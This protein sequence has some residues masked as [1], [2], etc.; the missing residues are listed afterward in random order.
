MPE[1]NQAAIALGEK[2]GLQIVFETARMYTGQAPPIAL[3]KI[4]GVTSFELG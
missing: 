4:Y 3:D 1:P 2:Y